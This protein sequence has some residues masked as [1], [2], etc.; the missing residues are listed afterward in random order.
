MSYRTST[1]S[2]AWSQFYEVGAQR[3]LVILY[4]NQPYYIHKVFLLSYDLIQLHE[5]KRAILEN[6]PLLQL[7]AIQ[8]ETNFSSLL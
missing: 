1:S 5:H 2:S 8:Y 4:T 7:R 3:R 6:C